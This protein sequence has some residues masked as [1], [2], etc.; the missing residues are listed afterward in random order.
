MSFSFKTLENTESDSE[1]DLETK[2]RKF[3]GQLDANLEEMLPIKLQ[4]GRLVRP[5]REKAV[6]KEAVDEDLEE[7]EEQWK[8]EDFSS[9]SASELL[10]KRRELLQETKDRISTVS[11]HLLAN[12]QENVRPIKVLA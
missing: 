4:D 9:L 7:K 10:A 8:P 6:A 2:K 12:P 5:T 11:S 3:D 1:E